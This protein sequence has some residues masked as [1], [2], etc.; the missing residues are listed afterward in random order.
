MLP[1]ATGGP[2]SAAA[3]STAPTVGHTSTVVVGGSREGLIY[4]DGRHT[5]YA[6]H[7]G[8]VAMSDV[9]EP[10]VTATLRHASQGHIVSAGVIH[11]PHCHWAVL[12][13]SQSGHTHSVRH[14]TV[15]E[16]YGNNIANELV[17]GFMVLQVVR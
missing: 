1:H 13:V 17:P 8:R 2:A 16:T 14:L 6:G 5:N 15:R 10:W 9:A 11:N 7:L 12:I 3:G 4:D